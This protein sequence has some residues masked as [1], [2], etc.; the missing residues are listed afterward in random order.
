M[1]TGSPSVIIDASTEHRREAGVALAQQWWDLDR[2]RQSCRL[3]EDLGFDSAW[4]TDHLRGPD[5][6]L[7]PF[8][9]LTYAAA[10]TER[11]RLGVAVAVSSARSP[12][13]LA[14]I[15][16]SVDQLSGGRL[17]LGIGSGAST[18]G[19]AFGVPPD[20]V[21]DRFRACVRLM[22]QLWRADNVTVDYRWWHLEDWDVGIRP[23]L[24]PHPP[25][26]IGDRTRKAL[27]H[28]VEQGTGWVGAGS[29]SIDDFT[30]QLA[31]VRGHLDRL[32]RRSGEFGIAKRVYLACS[33]RAELDGVTFDV[34][35][36]GAWFGHHYGDPAGADRFV[37]TGGVT[38]CAAQVAQV[39]DAGAEQSS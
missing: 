24:Q 12:V 23:Y 32:G 8:I 37:V 25:L 16:A 39:R 10:V 21:F 2:F 13:Q 6:L 28:A 4:V 29:S 9:A 3:A 1:T 7:D 5:A 38:A 11:I 15:V 31:V 27:H 14:Q 22:K 30:L 26:W 35:A 36:A 20:E 34:D 19:R 17:E 18:S 33:D